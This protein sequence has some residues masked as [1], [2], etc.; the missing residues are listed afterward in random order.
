MVQRVVGQA[1]RL[2]IISYAMCY[3]G[4]I[5]YATSIGTPEDGYEGEPT[6]LN[7]TTKRGY[8]VALKQDNNAMGI[9]GELEATW[10]YNK[11]QASFFNRIWHPYLPRKVSDMQ[12]LISTEG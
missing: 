9:D 4:M 5:G 11:A 10:F 3:G 1:M 2:F 8:R 6:I 12:W 7:Y